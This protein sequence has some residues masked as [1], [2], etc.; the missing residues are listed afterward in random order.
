MGCASSTTVAGGYAVGD[1]VYYG[2]PSKQVRVGGEQLVFGAA[3]EVV[4]QT[5]RGD[6]VVS[7][8]DVGRVSVRPL[9]LSRTAPAVPGGYCLGDRVYYGGPARKY[10]NG[11]QLF[12]S[13]QGQVAGRSCV[14]DNMDSERLAVMFPSH[15]DAKAVR[16]ALLSREPPVIPG[17][18]NVGD[19]VFWCG[20]NWTFPNGD[21]L[22]FGAKGEVAGRSCVGDGND[23]E[24]VAVNFPGNKGAVAMRLPEISHEPP[25]IP[26]GYRI[27]DRVFYAYPNWRAPDG[28]V[29][30]FGVQGKVIGRSCIG[31]GKDDERVWV[32]FPGLGYGCI[33]LEQISNEPPV[34][35][36][37]YSLGDR[38]F[39]GGPNRAAGCN[40]DRLSFGSLGEVA[41]RATSSRSSH[42]ADV[43]VVFPGNEDAVDVRLA[44]ISREVPVI[45]GNYSLGDYVFYGG[46]DCKFPNG[47]RLI[48][49]AR[50]EVAGRSCQGD[51]K[52]NERVAV[53]LPGNRSAVPL[54]LSDISREPP[55]GLKES[56]TE[57][58]MAA[59]ARHGESDEGGVD[60]TELA[61]VHQTAMGAGI[62]AIAESA[63]QSSI[64]QVERGLRTGD[65]AL[66]SQVL[67]AA[68]DIEWHELRDH[69]QRTLEQVALPAVLDAAEESNDIF[70]QLAVEQRARARG[71]DRLAARAAELVREADVPE[72]ELVDLQTDRRMLRNTEADT[73][74]VQQMQQ[75]LDET[76]T[77]WG[78]YGKRTRTRDRPNEKVADH[79]EVASVQQLRNMDSY[80]SY[81]IRRQVIAAEL[82]KDL[83]RDWGVRTKSGELSPAKHGGNSTVSRLLLSPVDPSLNEHY[84]W[85]GTGPA[86][87]AG[88]AETGFDLEQAGSS[89]G[90]LFGRGLYFAESCLKADEYVRASEN[91]WF[92]LI[93]CRVTLGNVN[94]CDAEDP[95]ELRDTF[96][97]SCRAGP[98]GHHSVLGDREKVR[99][100]FREFVVFDGHQA[101]PEYIVWYTR[102]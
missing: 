12:F 93:L 22:R 84:L 71:L 2:G 36:G 47:D 23:D 11:D 67:R 40:G 88:I 52:D 1:S 6:V 16:L 91:G 30:F 24:R 32:L 4:G 63:L 56:L 98:G 54:H 37:G 21:R 45:P 99:Q 42:K 100:T 94:Y 78:G 70:G 90:A 53:L 97:A 38:V 77:G 86:E 102:K 48:F 72:A 55:P 96:R 29:L 25:V 10:P 85:H 74:L 19:R 3:G 31:D 34:I 76:Y 75:L 28:H 20:M 89:R 27:G 41:G 13:A 5:C 14:G 79:L 59:S 26:G 87:A 92:P 82:P 61:V 35:P 7:F 50:G 58:F 101:Y 39:Y 80:L 81:C 17:G 69:A 44:E 18:Y 73:I 33:C 43:A 83:R 8:K 68:E 57:R 62:E 51:G 95:W 65:V 49:G 66:L 15:R 46:T 9:E 60:I 64:A